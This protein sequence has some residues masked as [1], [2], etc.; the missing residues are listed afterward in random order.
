MILCDRP[1]KTEDNL[2]LHLAPEVQSPHQLEDWKNQIEG[3]KMVQTTK[4]ETKNH[5]GRTT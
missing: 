2:R 1:R 4:T 5:Y 3:S